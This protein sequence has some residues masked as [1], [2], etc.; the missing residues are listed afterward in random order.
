MMGH[1]GNLVSMRKVNSG[2]G[3]TE[4]GERAQQKNSAPIHGV[5]HLGFAGAMMMA[6]ALK[7]CDCNAR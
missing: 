2:P 5:S 6:S 7:E 3:A 4:A 1:L